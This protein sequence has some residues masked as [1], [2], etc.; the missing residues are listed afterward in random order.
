MTY[1]KLVDNLVG[2]L[3]Y[4][5]IIILCITIFLLSN[6]KESCEIPAKIWLTVHMF[7]YIIDTS[8]IV[9]QLRYLK[10]HRRESLCIMAMRYLALSLIVG[11]LCYGNMLYYTHNNAKDC[12][13]GIRLIMFLSLILGYFEI[14]KCICIGAVLCIMIPYLFL[15]ARRARR[16]N[17]IPAAPLFI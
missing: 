14:L 11:W 16:P 4:S 6:L 10:S 2:E 12:S 15:A 1:K 8:F 7:L 9:L 3:V 17:W 13:G 5:I